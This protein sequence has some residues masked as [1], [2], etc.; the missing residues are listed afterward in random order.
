MKQPVV[1]VLVSVGLLAAGLS[2]AGALEG[3][4]CTPV[5][6]RV[7]EAGSGRALAGVEVAL[8]SGQAT[9]TD[10]GGRFELCAE[11]PGPVVL[12]VRPAGAV[13]LEQEVEVRAGEEVTID[14]DT[15]SRPRFA[16]EVTIVGA[17]ERPVE[18]AR[19][20]RPETVIA[21]PGAGED[22]LQTLRRPARRGQLDDW[23]SRL[24]VR[25]G[26]P[27]QNGI[28]IDGISVYDPYRLFGLTSLFN[29]ETLASVVLYPGGFDVRYGDRLS[30]VVAVENRDGTLDA[31]WPGARAS[32]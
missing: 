15:V 26:R 4:G 22:V 11:G 17:A 13:E 1:M 30:A 27:D 28:Y 5:V 24:Y 7:V 23:S 16:D 6:G 18:P 20:V 29:P 8:P 32:P 9:R 10:A 3:E 14:L 25:G 2:R 21:M 19:E 31:A 12:R